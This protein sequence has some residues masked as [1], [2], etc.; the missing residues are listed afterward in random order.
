M[1]GS[2]GPDCMGTG[3]MGSE[4]AQQDRKPPASQAEHPMTMG[5]PP[6]PWALSHHCFGPTESELE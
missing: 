4:A 5:Q 6:D 3:S 2:P 1:A